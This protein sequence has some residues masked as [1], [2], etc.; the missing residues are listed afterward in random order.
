MSEAG[1]FT[2]MAGARAEREAPHIG[3]GML[4]YAFMG[5]AH[6]NAY[7]KIPYMMYPPPAIPDLVAICGRSADAVAEAAKRYG[8]RRYYTD[9]RE[10]LADNEIQIF[11][12]GAPNSAHMAPSIAAAQAGK[13]VFCEKPLGR[14]PEESKAMLDAVTEAGVKHMVGFNYRFLPAIRLARELIETGKLGRI[15]HYRAT[16]LQEWVLPHYHT[17]M[18]WRLEKDVAGCGALGDLGTHLIDLGRFLV[19]EIE[20]V[21]AMTRIFTEHRPTADG[22][23]GSV[24]IDDAFVA[25]IG[26]RN[27][28][29]GTLE[30]TR[31][32]AGRKNHE[33]I[34]VNGENG[35][36][37]FDLERLN[38]LNVYWV[39]AEPKETQGFVNVKVSEPSHPW[40]SNWWP[41]GH[42]IGWEHGFIHELT[43]FIDCVVNDR[44]VGP[45]G[46]TF[47]D[48]YRADC[49]SSAILESARTKRHVDVAY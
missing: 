36:I 16:Y 6:S 13:H 4:G 26:F 21:A 17:P 5:K 12:N 24:E 39:G 10:M 42:M 49:V 1:G 45:Y 33:I 28:A 7:K 47:E 37:E 27:G 48:G 2:T 23:V 15:Y 20:S 35:S 25:S 31:F 22:R 44:D 41:Q 11:D 38:E 9:W 34:E 30:A 14:S 40:W 43:H 19:G 29:I 8:Y 18:T 3:I 32:A 46:A